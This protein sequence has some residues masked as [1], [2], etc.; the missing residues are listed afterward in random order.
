LPQQR[1]TTIDLHLLDEKYFD[2]ISKLSFYS[3]AQIRSAGSHLSKIIY[4]S[5]HG[6]GITMIPNA[7]KKWGFEKLYVLYEWC[8]S[9]DESFLVRVIHPNP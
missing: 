6:T 2:C 8:P 9:V 3:A 4:S 1:I 5:L 7:L